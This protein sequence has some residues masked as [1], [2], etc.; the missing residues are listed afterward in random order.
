MTTREPQTG[1]PQD[2]RRGLSTVLAWVSDRPP[3]RRPTRRGRFLRAAATTGL[4]LTAVAAWAVAIVQPWGH[5]AEPSSAVGLPEMTIPPKDAYVAAD[6]LERLCASLDG[7]APPPPLARDPFTADDG[8]GPSPGRTERTA[9]THLRRPTDAPAGRSAGPGAGAGDGPP[10]VLDT[11]KALRLDLTL[12]DGEGRRW[13]V[14][15]G[16]EYNEGDRIDGLEILEI[17]EGCV[18]LR[19]GDLVG[20][21]RVD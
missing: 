12:V 19:R 6:Q 1:R 20:I 9:E 4:L 7:P 15:D 8:G 3:G 13:A 14:I 17:Q 18:K 16:R 5:A 11:L 21:L 10:D 2:R